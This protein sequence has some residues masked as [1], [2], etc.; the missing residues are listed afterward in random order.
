[1]KKYLFQ[2]FTLCLLSAISCQ[3][4]D[5][6]PV[7]ET[8]P[9]FINGTLMH[10]S[11]VRKY[12]LHIPD[13]YDGLD[14]TPLVLF[15][16]GG[17][18]N[19]ESA[20]NFSNFNPV[21]D[22]YGFLMVYPEAFFE[23]APDNFVWAD[24]R[25]LAADKL[26]ID[27]VGFINALVDELKREYNIDDSRVYLCGFSNG[28]FLTQRIAFQGNSPFAAF[29]TLG[30]TM[31]ESLFEN[32][33]PG[34]AI[35]MM[36]VFGTDD[37]LVPYEGGFVSGNPDLEAV[38]GVEEAVDYWRQNNG[39]ATTLEKI[40]LPNTNLTDNSTVEVYE[41]TDCSC[42]ADVKFYKVIGAGHTWP[43]VFLPNQTSLGITNLDMFASEELWQ[44]FKKYSLCD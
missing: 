40:D 35:P 16:H 21:S 5:D 28:S 14:K 26:G 9:E 34:R 12:T 3:S 20:Q 39:C 33:D 29:G 1:M 25:G 23:S 13:S 36:Y 4:D 42:S 24:G 18:G 37:H 15:L 38:K 43:G 22:E 6:S 8:F 44:F 32:G 11:N 19:A 27:D 17:G 7:K 41:Y 31:N 2:F 10:Q 30:G